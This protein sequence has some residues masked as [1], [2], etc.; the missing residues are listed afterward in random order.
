MLY[1]QGMAKTKDSY[2]KVSVSEAGRLGGKAKVPKGLARVSPKKK[3]EILKLAAEARKRKAAD[4]SL[5]S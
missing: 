2:G 3:Q 1:W 4:R 5:D